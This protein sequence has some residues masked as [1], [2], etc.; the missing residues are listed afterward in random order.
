MD[1]A[2]LKTWWRKPRIRAQGTR[3]CGYNPRGH[4]RGISVKRSFVLLAVGLLACSSAQAQKEPCA[5]AGENNAF[6]GIQ[7]IRLWP[8][9]APYAKGK[10]C[11][12]TPTLTIF[13][14]QMGHDN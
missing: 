6:L 9:D 5:T 14:P 3:R 10:A 7:T 12:D 2:W 11:E 8:G 13:D 4:R 1:S